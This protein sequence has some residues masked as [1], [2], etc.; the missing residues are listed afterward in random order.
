MSEPKTI[1][2]TFALY[3]T[4]NPVGWTCR[5]GVITGQGPTIQ[6]ALGSWVEGHVRRLAEVRDK[7]LDGGAAG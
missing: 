1:V 5:D 4:T 7:T 6:A 2:L 3:D